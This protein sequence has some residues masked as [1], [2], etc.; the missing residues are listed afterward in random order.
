MILSIN[1][2]L[3]EEKQRD[4]VTIDAGTAG[5]AAVAEV[6]RYTDSYLVLD[7]GPLGTT[8]ARTGCMPSKT[9][10]QIAHASHKYQ[11]MKQ[12]GLWVG[13]S[14]IQIDK[15]FA[16]VRKMRDGFVRGVIEDIDSMG[17]H[18]LQG[19]ARFTGPN[20]VVIDDDLQLHAKRIIIATGTKPII[21]DEWPRHHQNIFTS[22]NFF[23]IEHAPQ[24]WAV[25]GMGPMGLE[26][27]Q[28]LAFLGCEVM[29]FDQ[30]SSISGLVDTQ[31]NE[32]ACK[33]IRNNMQLTLGQFVQVKESRRQLQVG[34]DQ[35]PKEVYAILSAIGRKPQLD[36]L[37][38]STT[39]YSVDKDGLPLVDR[40]TQSLLGTSIF[41][42]GDVD[43]ALPILHEAAD[44]GRIAGYNATRE[45]ISSFSRRTPL[46]VAFTSPGIASVGQIGE[47]TKDAI[48]GFAS[49]EDQ[50]RAKIMSENKGALQIYVDRT[51]S[52]IQG[53]EIVAPAAEHL[54]HLIAWAIQS[55]STLQEMLRLPFYH[56]T[57]EEG[58]RTALKH[59]ASQLPQPIQELHRESCHD[60]KS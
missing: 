38:L 33:A 1:E 48:V 41:F 13:N 21:P 43:R 35:G 3:H 57:I 39:D 47:S 6:K 16:L 12:A 17:E 24:R 11:C 54:A 26:L 46:A 8:C 20:A 37:D 19:Q 31:L 36:D 55:G 56:P 4:V 29:G 60:V 27:G 30:K 45:H 34:N 5:L 50:G 53:A 9:L 25:I 51:T 15:A 7:R 49:F 10:I 59:A 18:F 44:D 42:A 23:D 22:D 58:L 2:G 52:C 32:L 14:Q 40:E 28:A